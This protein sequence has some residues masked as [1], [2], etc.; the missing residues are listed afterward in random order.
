LTS[1]RPTMPPHIATIVVGLIIAVGLEQTVELI[2]HVHQRRE[3]REALRSTTEIND[4]WAKDDVERMDGRRHWALEP[5]ARGLPM[6]RN[7]M[8]HSR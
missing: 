6:L 4:A 1:T 8:H 2:H 7:A 3:L 5:S